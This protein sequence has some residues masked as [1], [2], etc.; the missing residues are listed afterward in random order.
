M[1]LKLVSR[2]Y[3]T[4]QKLVSKFLSS[5]ILIPLGDWNGHVGQQS[6]GFEVHGG[7]GYGTRNIEG[8][9]E[10]ALANNLI[11]GNTHFKKC[12]SHLITYSSGQNAEKWAFL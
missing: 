9:L 8:I 2:I 11:I 4:L 6:N 10:F 7:F 12:K 3:D 1:L 5:E